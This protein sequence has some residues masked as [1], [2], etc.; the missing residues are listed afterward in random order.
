MGLRQVVDLVVDP[1]DLKGHLAHAADRYPVT[2]GREEQELLLELLAVVVQH[3]EQ[4]HGVDMVTIYSTNKSSSS[5][6]D[7]TLL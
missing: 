7:I 4:C 2:S 3:L 1:G 6:A 5:S